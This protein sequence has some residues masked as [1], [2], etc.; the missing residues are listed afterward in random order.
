MISSARSTALAERWQGK[1]DYRPILSEV[2][3]EGLRSGLVTAEIPQ[4]LAD[5]GGIAGL[6]AYLCGPPGM[7]DAAVA[8]LTSAGV[9]LPAIHYDKFTDA[10]TK[11]R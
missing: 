4:A 8:A 10:S 5:L 2:P 1:F 9:A 11:A 7:I 3:A 6:Q